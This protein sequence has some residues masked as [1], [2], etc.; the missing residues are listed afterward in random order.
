[1]AHLAERPEQAATWIELDQD[2]VARLLDANPRTVSRLLR[3]GTEPRRDARERVLKLIAVLDQLSSVLRA[4]P[5]HDWL[6]PKSPAQQS[7]ARGPVA[8]G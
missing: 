3:Q 1:M 8:Q 4:T 6:D 2:E 5:A 7:H